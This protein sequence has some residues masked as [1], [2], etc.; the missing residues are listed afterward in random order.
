MSERELTRAQVLLLE[1]AEDEQVIGSPGLA[2]PVRGFHAQQAVE[3][4]LKALLAQLDIPYE[5]TLRLERLVT[6]LLA[7]GEVLPETTLPL[8]ELNDFA[9]FYRYDL[10]FE[11]AVPELEDVLAT[12][13]QVREHIVAHIVTLSDSPHPPPVQ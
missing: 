4:R 13:R 11:Y 3:K 5:R 9:V 6:V 10:I 1:A 8:S 7:S 2:D 12:V